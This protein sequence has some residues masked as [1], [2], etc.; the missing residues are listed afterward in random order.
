MGI[1]LAIALIPQVGE[2]QKAPVIY[3]AA[4]HYI[5]QSSLRGLDS[6]EFLKNQSGNP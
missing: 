3:I 5:F 4:L 2:V 1:K 6:G